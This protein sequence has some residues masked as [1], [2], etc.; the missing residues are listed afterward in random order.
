MP[1]LMGPVLSVDGMKVGMDTWRLSA[2]VV[3][4]SSPGSLAWQ[5][6]IEQHTAEA[7]ALWHCDGL[8]VFRFRFA[9]PLQAKPSVFHYDVAGTRHAVHLPAATQSPHMAYASCNGFSSPSA[10]KRIDDNNAMWSVMQTQHQ[11]DPYHLL[12]LGGDQVYADEMWAT[13][14]SLRHWVELD[15]TSAH[16]APFS[17]TMQ[18]EIERF[19]LRLY[20][21]RWS[22]PAI[23]KMLACVPMLAM[24]DDHDIF[25]GWGSYQEER[26]NCPV[27]QGIWPIARRAFAAFQQQLGD[28]E[29]RSSAIM[30]DNSVFSF[31]MVLPSIA[32]LALDMRSERTTKRVLSPAHWQ[33]VW[34]WI[35]Q[36][37]ED[38]EHLML[39]SSIPVIYPGFDT[40]E[41][42]FGMVPGRQD[43]EDDLRDHWNT[44]P[45]KGER[46]R[47]IHRLLALAR[48]QHIRPT[49]L[50]GDVHVA[51]LG[52]LESSREVAPGA[53]AGVINQLISSGIVHPGPGKPVLFALKHFFSNVDEVDTSISARM[54]EFPGTQ[55]RFIGQ[56]NYLDLSVDASE[57]G[58]P[59]RIWANWFIEGQEDPYVKVVHPLREN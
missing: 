27:F 46:L 9:V 33:S 28:G 15:D 24:W 8:T 20:V 32:I 34:N 22:Q 35:S 50:S 38:V 21:H 36:L 10:M 55:Q 13:V 51:A 44:I 16:R 52:V 31:G 56:R 11:A 3:A 53:R 4:K 1:M 57:H 39:M 42:L 40:L 5:N 54:V 19:Y 2:L 48:T 29:Q 17:R 58:I 49:I 45:H 37:P 47:L 26:Q 59:R 18:R 7:E 14:P 43:L 12:L 30:A 6:E 25:D 41:G 23:A